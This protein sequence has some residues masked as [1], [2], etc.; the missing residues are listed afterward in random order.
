MSV[1]NINVVNYYHEGKIILPPGVIENPKFNY[2]PYKYNFS[3]PDEILNR[4]DVDFK[5]NTALTPRGNEYEWYEPDIPTLEQ[6]VIVAR[7]KNFIYQRIVGPPDY[8]VHTVDALSE[9][10][11]HFP[12][13]DL[14]CFDT[15]A[16]IALENDSLKYIGE[17]RRYVNDEL[18]ASLNLLDSIKSSQFFYNQNKPSPGIYADLHWSCI[19]D[20]YYEGGQNYPHFIKYAAGIIHE[21]THKNVFVN[22]GADMHKEEVLALENQMLCFAMLLQ[23]NNFST[24]MNNWLETNLDK[25]ARYFFEHRK[26]MLSH[27]V[28]LLEYG[29][30]MNEFY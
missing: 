14:R 5:F 30:D 21:L 7:P 8:I 4:T 6:N 23:N 11:K 12:N 25:L 10:D 28:E 9:L 20:Y 15:I 19:F 17:S 3:I 16:T 24:K 22:L 1:E 29:I 13:S 2:E 18:L 27:Y 26:G